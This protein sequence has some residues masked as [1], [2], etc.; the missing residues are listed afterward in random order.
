MSNDRYPVNVR[1]I[2]VM[3]KDTCKMFMTSAMWSDQ[4]EIIVYRSFQDFKKL[5]KQLK[6]KFPAERHFRNTD[7][8][9]PKFRGIK[10]Q[11]GFQ[12]KGPSKSVDRL[13]FLE[14][15]CEQLL[16]SDL[17][18]IQ[19]PEVA[20]FFLPTAQDLQ[21]DFAKNSIVIMP[22]D[23]V[24]DGKA[25]AGT[26]GI[27]VG[28]VTQPFVTEAYRCIA[29]YE[30]K[31][32]KNRA[33]K[34]AVEETVDVLIK[35][36]AGWW[37]VENS[38]KCMAWFPAP[39]LEKCE[40][41]EEEEEEDDRL[42]GTPEEGV[43]Y[44]AVKNYKSSKGDEVSVDIGGVVEV[45]QKSDNGWWLIRYKGKAGYIPSM[46]LQPYRNPQV[47]FVSLQKEMWSSALNLT[48][49]QVPGVAPATPLSGHAHHLSRS[50]SSLLSPDDWYRS[51]GRGGG[52][53]RA[54]ALGS[55]LRS[56]SVEIPPEPPRP[57]SAQPTITV[58]APPPDD[59][60]GLGD[61]QSSLSSEEGGGGGAAAARRRSL[62]DAADRMRRSLTPQP[63]PRTS[64]PGAQR[65]APSRSVPNLS[66]CPVT[67]KVPPRPRAQEILNRCTSV[68]RKA[69]Q[70]NGK[71]PG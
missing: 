14:Q 46:Y 41:E 31:D 53:P 45:L 62:P 13:K 2:G 51:D 32:T 61:R 15:Y 24:H 58:E 18:V 40:D 5:H 39:Y 42:P 21:P 37:L 65:M 22:S 36:K 27:N 67:P 26:S 12:K 68:T 38:S 25:A 63:A 8:Q 23:D 50:Q 57:F 60:Q 33:F 19:S 35:D 28:N 6:K 10:A 56:R 69:A 52:N 64:T 9:I 4:S 47:R 43:L 49:L 20:Q 48:Q 7:R 44:T 70:S 66:Q 17:L 54:P 71:R 30:T 1:L 29:P 59:E 34:V 3:H 55:Q 11:N 16:K